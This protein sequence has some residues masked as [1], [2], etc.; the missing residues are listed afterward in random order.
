MNFTQYNIYL[1]G[2]VYMRSGIKRMLVFYI[3]K[4]ISV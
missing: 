3:W 1:I 4:R 2:V